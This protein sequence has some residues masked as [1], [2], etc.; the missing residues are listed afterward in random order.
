MAKVVIVLLRQPRLHDPK[1][2]RTDP[3]W[4]FGSFGCTRCHRTNLMNPNRL[5][6]HNG[7][8][9]AFAQGGGMGTKLVHVTAPI[10]TLH[11]GTFGEA[12]WEPFDMPLCYESAPTLV[13]NTNDSDVPA[14]VR[15]ISGVQRD[16][17]VA[18]FASKFR[19]RRQAL[20]DDVGDELL[21]VYAEFRKKGAAV[22]TGYE[23]A[24]PYTPPKVD[25]DRGGTYRRLLQLGDKLPTAELF[26]DEELLV[27]REILIVRELEGEYSVAYAQ[28]LLCLSKLL[29]SRDRYEEA[30]D[31]QRFAVSILE[32]DGGSAGQGVIDRLARIR[33]D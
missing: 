14:L 32:S 16:T 20:P 18:R 5:G 7:V 29:A 9:L 15:M 33:S 27:R 19:S 17:P 22:A 4:E 26:D 8:R 10:R 13:S 30:E 1:E 11:H 28:S 31:V 6:E 12:A 23:D 2:M 3:L 25:R 24:L 21:R